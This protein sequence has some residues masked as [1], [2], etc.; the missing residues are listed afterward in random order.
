MTNM[1]NIIE[2]GTTISESSNWKGSNTLTIETSWFQTWK[3][4]NLEQTKA[5]SLITC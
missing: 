2:H 3:D 5:L 4:R 1:Q